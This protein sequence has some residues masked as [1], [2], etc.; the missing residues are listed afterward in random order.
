MRRITNLISAQLRITLFIFHISATDVG[1]LPTSMAE[2][3]RY[4]Y[5][6]ATLLSVNQL[7]GKLFFVVILHT[8]LEY[9]S[10]N[11][12]QH[13]PHYCPEMKAQYKCEK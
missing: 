12:W 4:W 10:A 9:H 3:Y 8:V 2:P 7:F 5:C 11:Y 1:Y 6:S 13:E